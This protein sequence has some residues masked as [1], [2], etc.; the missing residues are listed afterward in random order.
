MTKVHEV[1]D[2]GSFAYETPID[3]N[4]P[5]D[6]KDYES[7]EVK[8]GVE[9]RWLRNPEQYFADEEIKDSSQRAIDSFRDV[10]TGPK[11]F[12]KRQSKT[13]AAQDGVVEDVVDSRG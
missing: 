4:T 13:N 1:I 10:L 7:I 3:I 2:D 9:Y 8:N 12:M 5:K 6:A 11:G